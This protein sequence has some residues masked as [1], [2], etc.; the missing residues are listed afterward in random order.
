MPTGRHASFNSRGM[1]YD[2]SPLVGSAP[3]YCETKPMQLTLI[4]DGGE[5]CYDVSVLENGQPVSGLLM[6]RDA[7]LITQ[8]DWEKLG[9]QIIEESNAMADGFVDPKD[10]PQ[11]F[12]DLCTKIEP[13][14]VASLNR[15]S[16]RRP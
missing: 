15:T 7:E 13:T 8:H 11:F 6:K 4:Q 14:A 16:S 5:D 10:M 12:R 3:L 9:F 1:R 2:Y